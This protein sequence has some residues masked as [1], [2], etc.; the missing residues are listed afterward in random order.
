[1]SSPA[2]IEIDPSVVDA[3]QITIES[4]SVTLMLPAPS[5]ATSSDVI[6]DS[7]ITFPFDVISRCSASTPRS[8]DPPDA[9]Y[10][11]VA[12]ILLSSSR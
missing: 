12:S 11:A 1:M 5:T 2:A 8:T 4:S 10:A 7:I 3:F 6:D 9:M